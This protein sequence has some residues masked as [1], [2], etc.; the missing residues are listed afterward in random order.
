VATPFVI[1]VSAYKGGVGKTTVAIEL[2][3]ALGAVLVDLDWDRGGATGT[4]STSRYDSRILTGLLTGRPPRP[5]RSPWRPALVPSHPALAEADLD[6]AEAAA[7]LRGWAEEWGQPVVCDTHPG[8]VILTDAAWA[9]AD[10]VVVPTTIGWPEL[11][12]LDGLLAERAA[13][14]PLL[15]VP[16]R[17]RGWAVVRPQLIELVNLARQHQVPVAPP[18]G[19]HVWLSRRRLRFALVLAPRPGRTVA[20]AAA[21]FR[22]VAEAVQHALEGAGAPRP[23]EEPAHV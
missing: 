18:I 20:A 7:R 16:N 6:P 11:R 9:A 3:A 23:T 19:E 17:L 15:L 13:K 22:A 5:L 21:E 12:A 1:A 2:A 8:A 4:L 10:L 14:F